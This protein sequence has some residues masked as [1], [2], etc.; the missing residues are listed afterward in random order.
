[1]YH[2]EIFGNP[3]PQKQTRATCKCGGVR[4]Y[5]P[6]K[7]DKEKIQWQIR[8]FAPTRP[9]TGPVEL[10]IAFFVA[11]PKATPRALREQMINRVIL[12]DKKPDEDNLAYLITNA[13]KEI[14]YDDDRRVVAKHVYKFYGDEPKTVVRVRPILEAQPLGFRDVDDL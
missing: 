10:T 14:V 2:F 1:M 3:I 13:L 11:I 6:S 8:P 7:Q 9:I 5:D 4:F 12:P